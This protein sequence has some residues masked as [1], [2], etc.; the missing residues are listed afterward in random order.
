M[1][2]EARAIIILTASVFAVIGVTSLLRRRFSGETC[3]KIAH[4]LL[5]NWIIIALAV[6]SSTATVVIP[7]A[8]FVVVNWI[9]WRKNLFSGIERE[10]DNT[11]GTVWFAVSLVLL[12]AFF[13][14]IGSPWICACGILAMGY[15]DGFAALIGIRFGKHPFPPP[16]SGKTAEG[17]ITAALF[18]GLAVGIVSYFYRPD[19]ALSAGFACGIIAASAELVSSNGFD[20][21]TLPVAVSFSMYSMV[22]HPVLIPVFCCLGVTLIVLV[23]AFYLRAVTLAGGIAA[24]LLGTALF[25]WGGA[26]AY[27]AL[28]AFFLPCSIVSRIGK[29]KKAE[30]SSLHRRS[31]C[32]GVAQVAANGLPALI[33]AAA[34]YF[35]GGAGFLTAVFA[36]LC[37]AS[38][39]T[40]SSEIGMLSKSIPRSILTMRPVSRGI[41]GGVT[42]TGLC[43]AMLGSLAIAAIAGPARMAAVFLAG[44]TGSLIDSCL[45]ASCQVKYRL[46][47]GGLTEKPVADGL[48]LPRACGI[49][50]LGNDAVNFLS[51]MASSALSILLC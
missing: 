13:W 23:G 4:I 49:G 37:A 21:F 24:L 1:L 19:I 16:F 20:N 38:A 6:F 50:W 15:G 28:M 3:R 29:E 44:V 47:N 43:G 35:T 12:C 11:P 45:G 9:S 17:T 26:G 42:L 10:K 7:P 30:P 2:R 5:S 27:C 51:I 39:D 48:T 46:P 22:A 31:G 14:G 33:W 41:S 36:S 40:F 8:I 18:S 34:Y 32:R 25:I